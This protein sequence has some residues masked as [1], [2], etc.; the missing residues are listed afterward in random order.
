MYMIIF[1]FISLPV[2]HSLFVEQPDDSKEIEA[3]YV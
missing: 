1:F 2:K 3:L